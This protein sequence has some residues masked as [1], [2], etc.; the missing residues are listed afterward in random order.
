M[1]YGFLK[2]VRLSIFMLLLMSGGLVFQGC[3][4]KAL[5]NARSDFYRG[6]IPAAVAALGDEE[7]IPKRDLLLFYMEKGLAL[8]EM[9][10]FK[11][12]IHVLLKATSLMEEQD[13]VS[14]SSQTASIMTTDKLTAYKGEYSER[15][16]VHTYLMM[17]FLL[18]RQYDSALVEAKQALA[19]FESHPK[20]LKED[21]FT[22]A[23]IALCFET[24]GEVN[25]AYIEYKKLDA[26]MPDKGSIAPEL[27][28]LAMKQGFS[29]EAAAY[30]KRIPEADRARLKAPAPSELVLFIGTGRIP[31][32][33]PGDIF[34]PPAH[35]FSFPYY[36]DRFSESP[37]IEPMGPQGDFFAVT[38]HT[39]MGDVAKASLEE[40][41]VAVIAKETAR[42]AAREMIAR[43]L[44]DDAG[45]AAG[46][47]FRIA[48]LFV[49]EADIR[50]WQTLPGNLS[51]VRIPLPEGE[52]AL[53]ITLSG[54]HGMGGTATLPKIKLAK[55]K[56][57]FCSIR[58]NETF[59]PF[60][61]EQAENP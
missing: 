43:K 45:G 59:H 51:L 40:R 14:L 57:G 15:L 36:P 18:T 55:G 24:V 4:S 30:E 56:K 58:L 23:L 7:E 38:V 31:E 28:R 48:F 8:H 10:A 1:I 49:G 26:D 2:P 6:D 17:N 20:P 27:Y 16:W 29:D 42:V 33:A 47:L 13:V 9:G 54:G 25:G 3:A 19:L 52:H 50:C 39:R 41:R 32:K 46:A 11:E 12:S 22:R 21:Y 44:D 35:R 60:S 53:S 37:F 5:M 34:I 61:P